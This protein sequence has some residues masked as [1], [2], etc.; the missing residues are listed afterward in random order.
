MYSYSQ[1]GEA[2]SFLLMTTGPQASSVINGIMYLISAIANLLG[3]KTSKAGFKL[4]VLLLLH[5]QFFVHG[6]KVF[7]LLRDLHSDGMVQST[8]MMCSRPTPN[9]L[10]IK[11]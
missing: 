4:C 5:G 10:R 1:I 3:F 8:I 2:I 6:G 11:P 9:K 7:L